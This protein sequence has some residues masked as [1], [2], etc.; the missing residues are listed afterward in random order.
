MIR[1]LHKSVRGLPARID[2]ALAAA[3]SPVRSAKRSVEHDLAAAEHG[4]L[5]AEPADVGHAVRNEDR[6]LALGLAAKDDFVEQL[7]GREI[8]ALSRLVE[9]QQLGIVDQGLGQGQPL[10]HAFAVGGDGFAGA[11]GQ[12][13]FVQQPRNSR[14][15]F[16]PRS[17]DKA[18]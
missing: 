5:V 14:R 4:Q 10:E 16:P 1:L 11:I 12:A 6:R 3:L 13:D 17:S 7:A 18:P 8:H 15:Q 2:I 9:H